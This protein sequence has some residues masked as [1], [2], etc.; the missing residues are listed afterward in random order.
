MSFYKKNQK[1]VTIFWFFFVLKKLVYVI[2]QNYFEL[3]DIYRTILEFRQESVHVLRTILSFFQLMLAFF[4]I[5]PYNKA[6]N[7]SGE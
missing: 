1:I 7:L 6:R 3:Q 2:S 5:S 4:R